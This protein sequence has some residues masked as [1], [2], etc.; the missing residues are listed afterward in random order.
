MII[1]RKNL[2]QAGKEIVN[3]G[4][5]LSA[6]L[7]GIGVFRGFTINMIAVGEEG[8]SL[9]ESLNEVA[10]VYEKEVEQAI[11]LMTSIL[12]PLLIL[13]VG[14]IV[15]FIVLAILMPILNMS[16]IAR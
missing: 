15:G 4:L 14:L 16:V 5:T 7:K 13:I 8:G 1:L 12:E 6:S 10:E 9:E 11:R 2:K 3:R